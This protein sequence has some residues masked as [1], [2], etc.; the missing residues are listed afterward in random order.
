MLDTDTFHSKRHSVLFLQSEITNEPN[1]SHVRIARNNETCNIYPFCRANDTFMVRHIVNSHRL[2]QPPTTRM[3][4]CGVMY[5][6]AVQQPEVVLGKCTTL[7][8]AVEGKQICFPFERYPGLSMKLRLS[9]TFSSTLKKPYFPRNPTDSAHTLQIHTWF[10][11]E[12]GQQRG[13][14]E[15]LSLSVVICD[16]PHFNAL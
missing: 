15:K 16:A 1:V 14:T 2:P 6:S 5:P 9:G 8:Y 3:A 4:S 12:T 7:K 10:K 13:E 11:P